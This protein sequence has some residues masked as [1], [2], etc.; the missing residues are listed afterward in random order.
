MWEVVPSGDVW[1]AIKLLL[2]N[3][4]CNLVIAQELITSVEVVCNSRINYKDVAIYKQK[5]PWM[6][7]MELFIQQ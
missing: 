3:N 6:I 4:S 1:E 5:L 2:S 7:H